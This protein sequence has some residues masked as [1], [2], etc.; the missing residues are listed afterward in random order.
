[1][2]GSPFYTKT[3]C[4]NTLGINLATLRSYLNSN[5]IYKHKWVF[6][7]TTLS[8]KDFLKWEITKKIKKKITGEL[9]GDGHIKYESECT[10][11]LHGRLVFTFSATNFSYLKYL[12]F[13]ALAPICTNS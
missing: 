8:E 1:V 13:V 6:S 5:K 11:H 2:K 9:L 3:D 12:K 10:P 4:A 7:N